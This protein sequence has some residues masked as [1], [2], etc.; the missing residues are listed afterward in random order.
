[1]RNPKPPAMLPLRLAGAAI[2][3]ALV[4][5][6]ASAGSRD[7]VFFLGPMKTG[8]TSLSKLFA[9]KGYNTC[10]GECM[11]K[12]WAVVTRSNS[13]SSPVLS[14]HDAFMDHGD[15]ADYVW[16]AKAYPTARFVLNTRELKSWIV[17]RA[18]H[19][20]RNRV[21]AGCT[22]WGTASTCRRANS[23]FVDNS[24]GKIRSW[25]IDG[26]EHQRKVISFFDSSS[27]LRNRFAVVDVEGQGPNSLNRVL[28]WVTRVNLKNMPTKTVVLRPKDV[29]LAQARTDIR[30]PDANSNS[31]SEA[32]KEHVVK[33]IKEL[34]CTV[35]TWHDTLYG[36]C[37]KQIKKNAS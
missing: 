26:A 16:L 19:A 11:G 15:H 33:V 18:D 25:I 36:P 35:A 3:L 12:N 37:A 30:P 27:Q 8:T 14:Q 10:H 6:F 32:T 13:A 31:H 22:P 9:G 17:S 23:N 4:A 29:P 24:A 5:A 1:V 2:A 34:G 28:D 21:A 7:K 20:R